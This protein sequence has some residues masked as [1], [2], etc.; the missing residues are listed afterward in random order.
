MS[1]NMRSLA[2][3]TLVAAIS[4]SLLVH[5]A[6]AADPAS[7]GKERLPPY[8]SPQ[9]IPEPKLFQ[10]ASV[11]TS[12]FESHPA[13]LPGGRTLFYVKSTPNRHFHTIVSTT[14]DSAGWS[15]PAVAPFSGKYADSD[16]FITADGQRMYFV[17]T[18]AGDDYIG[19]EGTN[20]ADLW[21]VEKNPEG[22]WSAP[23]NAGTPPNSPGN[24]CSPAVAADGRS[25]S[26]RTARREGRLRPLPLPPRKRCLRP[27]RESRGLDQHAGERA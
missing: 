25:T 15:T 18:R 4:G 1:P 26:A 21:W 14:H 7:K 13:F 23:K 5:I 9:P 6:G 24:E 27:C 17:S 12:D 22:A 19:A 16:P 3:V 20:H 2:A 11:S 8:H 10:N